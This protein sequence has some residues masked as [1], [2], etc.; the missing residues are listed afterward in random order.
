M[1]DSVYASD[2]SGLGTSPQRELR[3]GLSGLGGR[4]VLHPA[5]RPDEDEAD[6]RTRAERGFRRPQLPAAVASFR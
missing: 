1:L 3:S 6:F 2:A 5:W 4:P